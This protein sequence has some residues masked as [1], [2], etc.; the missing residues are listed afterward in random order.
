M[1]HPLSKYGLALVLRAN[2]LGQG[3]VD[4]VIHEMLIEQLEEGLRHFRF[5]TNSDPELSEQLAYKHY[6]IEDLAENPNLVQS[7]GLSGKGKFLS[8]NILTEEKSAK[9]VYR[10]VN[11]LIALLEKESDLSKSEAITMSVSPV[12]GKVNQGKLSQSNPN[13]SLLEACCYAIGNIHP[14]KPSFSVNNLNYG[15]IPDLSL[16]EL[17]TFLDFFDNMY[18]NCRP[19]LLLAKSKDG[20]YK[21]PLIIR[22]NYPD[23]PF[24]AV[25]GPV[26][27]IASIGKW[28]KEADIPEGRRVLDLLGNVPIYL[29]GY[30]KAEVLRFSHY[31]VDLA[32][33]NKLHKIILDLEN[34]TLLSEE[35]K[36]FDNPKYQQFHLFTIRFLQLFSEAAFK[37]FLSFRAYYEPKVLHLLNSYFINVELEQLDMAISK[38]IVASAK[39][40]GRWLNYA[41]YKAAIKSE[42]NSAGRDAVLKSKA[43]FLVELESAA[44]SSKTGDELIS[45][46]VTRAGRLSGM[47]VPSEAQEFM[48][49]T[50]AET[51]TRE[52]AQHLITAYSR[53]R[54]K[55]QKKD[56][57]VDEEHSLV[58]E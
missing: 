17:I 47:D 6:G 18:S 39:E 34:S 31:L 10:A 53:L 49:A 11:K 20:K 40:M 45:H 5:H 33:E 24:H 46:V 14:L 1:N 29:F 35:R 4:R 13:S 19:K 12:S 57:F 30:G 22:G 28:S 36:S 54:N 38:E 3:E 51:I 58:P 41:A 32:K 8:Q 56:E 21:R 2:K 37:D 9:Q 55:H 52:Q 16:E 50:C 43:K 44:F 48:D 42:D 7:A 23:A 26:G 25:F 15:L 27:L